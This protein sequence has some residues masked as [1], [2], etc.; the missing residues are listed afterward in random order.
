[1]AHLH[2]SSLTAKKMQGTQ[3]SVC[4]MKQPYMTLECKDLPRVLHHAST[5]IWVWQL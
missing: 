5:H 2:G 1:M 4:I 3:G